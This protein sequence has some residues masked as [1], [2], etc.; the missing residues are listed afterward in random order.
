MKR[1]QG[2]RETRPVWWVMRFERDEHGLADDAKEVARCWNRSEADA[3]RD[4]LAG[5]NADAAVHYEVIEVEATF[6]YPEDESPPWISDPDR[7]K[8]RGYERPPSD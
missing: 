1:V 5:A 4:R 2:I 8:K 7:W 3:E 6:V